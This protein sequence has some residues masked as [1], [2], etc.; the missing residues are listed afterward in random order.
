VQ[1]RDLIGAVHD[2]WAFAWPPML[3]LAA[4]Y[5][6][7]RYID[8]PTT[9]EAQRAFATW[10]RAHAASVKSLRTDVLEPYGIHGITPAVAAVAVVFCLYVVGGPLQQLANL[11]PPRVSFSPDR[12]IEPTLAPGLV[13]EMKREYP[14][15]RT[16]NEAYYLALDD[17]RAATGSAASSHVVHTAGVYFLMQRVEQ[18]AFWVALIVTL[19]FFLRR[20]H[21]WKKIRRLVTALVVVS[22][23]WIVTFGLVLAN[24]EQDFFRE[25]QPVAITLEHGIRDGSS[26]S[27]AGGELVHWLP[28]SGPWWHVRFADTNRARWLCRTLAPALNDRWTC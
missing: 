20:G 22:A 4:L 15:A 12:L 25:W 6:L 19:C 27:N 23:L 2:A 10:L 3:L 13:D 18:S 8:S 24:T 17:T 1:V 26:A 5:A 21:R 28:E 16:F 14:S 9:L 11:L 7:S